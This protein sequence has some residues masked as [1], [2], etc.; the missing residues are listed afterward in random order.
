MAELNST[1]TA[2]ETLRGQTDKLAEE[3][4]AANASLETQQSQTATLKETIKNKSID[5]YN[6]TKSNKE[7]KKE[8]IALKHALALSSDDVTRLTNIST[9]FDK[10]MQSETE[11]QSRLDNAIEQLERNVAEKES[12]IQKLEAD[13]RN[14]TGQFMEVR[15]RLA[16]AGTIKMHDMDTIHKHE[17]RITRLIEE[18]AEADSYRKKLTA[19]NKELLEALNEKQ[20]TAPQ[21]AIVQEAVQE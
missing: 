19:K 15:D 20:A 2:L 10:Q 4:K 21:E 9:S 8:V 11:V 5:L 14:R 12:I 17:A 6:E 1:K 16:T 13:Y 3:L 18:I 7:L